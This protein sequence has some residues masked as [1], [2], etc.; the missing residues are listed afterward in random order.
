MKEQTWLALALAFGLAVGAA[1]NATAYN[2][3]FA[4]GAG[5][6]SGSAALVS[7]LIKSNTK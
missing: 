5:V 2:S 1:Q 7:G 6:W 4:L 3:N